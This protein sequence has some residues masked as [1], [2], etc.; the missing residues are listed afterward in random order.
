M[1]DAETAHEEM[2]ASQPAL[3]IPARPNL[4][5]TAVLLEDP[6]LTASQRVTLKRV[7]SD[8][9]RLVKKQDVASTAAGQGARNEAIWA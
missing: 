1:T 2:N 6:R 9:T 4:V 8:T 3:S 7:L 5:E